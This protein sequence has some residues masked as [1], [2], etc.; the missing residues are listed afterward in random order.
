MKHVRRTMES[1]QASRVCGRN[2][3]LLLR[4]RGQERRQPLNR[5]RSYPTDGPSPYQLSL[6][7]RTH[8]RV[9]NGPN[10]HA[11]VH[12]HGHATLGLA[13]V[14]WRS[15]TIRRK[16]TARTSRKNQADERRF[17]DIRNNRTAHGRLMLRPQ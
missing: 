14:L 16:S 13:K 8:V 7:A 5:V 17:A 6:R 10:V 11:H 4:R 1:W 12:V 15:R 3:L 2:K 9:R